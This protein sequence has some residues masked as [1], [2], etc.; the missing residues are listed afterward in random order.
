M[1]TKGERMS[2]HQMWKSFAF[3]LILPVWIKVLNLW[4]AEPLAWGLGTFVWIWLFYLL[5]PRARLRT[6]FIGSLLLS[7]LGAFLIYLLIVL[8]SS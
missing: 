1:A 4:L 5:P 8:F 2:R 6:N 7:V 3:G